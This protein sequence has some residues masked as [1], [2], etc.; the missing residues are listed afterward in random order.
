MKRKKISI[1]IIGCANIAI[2]SVIPAIVKLNDIFELHGIASRDSTK[3]DRISTRF[4]TKSYYSYDDLINDKDIQAVYIPLPNSLHAEYIKKAIEQ[5]LH[6]LVEKSLACSYETALELNILAKKKKCVIIENFQFRFHPQIDV[7][8][9][10]ILND[11]IGDIRSLRSSFGFPPFKDR[12]NIRYQKDLGGGSLYDA[13]AYPIKISQ[14][15]LGDDLEVTSSSLKMDDTSEVDLWGGGFLK[16][17]EG[18]KFAEVAFGFDNFYQCNLELWGN[19]GIIKANRIFTAPPD[20]EA[21]ILLENS[22]GKQIVKV[23]SSNHFVNMLLY[24]YECIE[25]RSNEYNQNVNQS[26]LLEEFKLKSI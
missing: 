23:K 3:A 21:E 15:F 10:L 20:Y 6:V 7:I 24:F 17:K 16:Q 5:N 8:N 19:K 2:R 22:K 4:N 12:N 26:R 11:S 13:G 14:M 18:Y 9:Q 25:N 1:G